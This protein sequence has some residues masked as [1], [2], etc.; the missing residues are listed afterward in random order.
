MRNVERST[1]RS[2]AVQRGLVRT[3]NEFM[4]NSFEGTGSIFWNVG[5]K[6]VN[7]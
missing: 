6:L 5:S 4:K 1:G 3:Y 2:I 7:P